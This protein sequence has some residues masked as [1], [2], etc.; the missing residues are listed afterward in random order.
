M[1]MLRLDVLIFDI[2]GVLVDVSA[3]YRDATRRAVQLY[4]ESAL[5]LA[6]SDAELISRAD[7]AAFKLAGGFNNDW[8]L[9]T[10]LLEYFVAMLD[11]PALPHTTPRTCGEV[12][13]FLRQAG[14]HVHTTVESLHAQKN[15]RAFAE[16]LRAAGGGLAA[17]R[18][19][20]GAR[21]AHLIFAEGEVCGRNLVK[22]IFEE[23]YL[24]EKLFRKEYGDARLVYHDDG[25]IHHEHLIPNPQSL[26]SLRQ[27]VLLGIATG[28]PRVQARYAL[29]HF[30][31]REH[32]RALVALEDIY[33]AE[34][35]LAARRNLSKPHPFTLLE[36][37][38]RITTRKRARCA[39][40]GDTPDDIRAANAAK[41]QMDF[42]AIGC[43]AA[44][45]DQ[46]ALR[47][48]FERVGADVIVEHP[49]ALMELVK[50]K[51]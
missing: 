7:V 47:R 34:E 15:I 17:V 29:E 50:Q 25:L 4:L 6:R 48:E 32:F 33:A 35:R 19:I 49:D 20:L 21:N 31:I 41:R 23:V 14:K 11:A 8:D 40:I 16:T 5:G 45:E 13:A 28:R 30:N 1:T 3:S 18:Q 36:A 42:V 26:I 10:G 12:I 9:T 22:R 39:Y 24:G 51:T 43:L 37:A 44:A 38:R 27:R 46:E 2:D